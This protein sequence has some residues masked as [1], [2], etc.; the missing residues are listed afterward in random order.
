[1]TPEREDGD[2]C[3]VCGSAELTFGYGFAGGGGI[4]HYVMCLGCERIIAKQVDVPGESL[5]LPPP[6]PDDEETE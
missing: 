4:G 6:G 3:S 2:H 5:I 1:M